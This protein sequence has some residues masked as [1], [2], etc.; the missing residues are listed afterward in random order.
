VPCLT[1]GTEQTIQQ[2]LGTAAGFADLCPGAVFVAN[3]PILMGIGNSSGNRLFTAGYPTDLAQKALIKV[4]DHTTSWPRNEPNSMIYAEGTDLRT[5]NLRLNG[6]RA[7]NAFI[8]AAALVRIHGFRNKVDGIYGTDP[9][10]SP[11]LEAAN[12]GYC[13]DLTD[14]QQFHRPSWEPYRCDI[15]RYS[16]LGRRNPDTL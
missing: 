3:G 13:A 7:N 16:H 10:G 12:P 11:G 2:A 8:P 6:N 15:N 14:H 9:L 1:G 4:S 5:Q